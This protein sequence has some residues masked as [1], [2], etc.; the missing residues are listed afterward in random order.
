MKEE[1]RKSDFRV[2]G[3]LGIALKLRVVKE[4]VIGGWKM[5][6]GT[7]FGGG[8]RLGI[9]V[10]D[11]RIQQW[12]KMKRKIKL[13]SKHNITNLEIESDSA[14]LVQLMQNSDNSL[15]PLGSMLAGCDLMMAKFQN[16]KLT[17][18]FR[19]CNMTAD[20]L[21][22][23]SIFHELGLVTLTIPLLMLPKLSWM[24]CLM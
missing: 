22:K 1:K 2:V 20:A 16:V 4:E 23:N 5:F 15:H 6:K 24:I 18:I 14:V 3:G 8:G 7:D 10:E 19:E 9:V 17:H 13:A 21:V 12:I 11:D